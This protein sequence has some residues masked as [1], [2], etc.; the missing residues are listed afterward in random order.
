MKAIAFLSNGNAKATVDML[1]WEKN[2]GIRL[3]PLLRVLSGESFDPDD[4]KVVMGLSVN[5]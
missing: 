4:S 2:S 1:H 3:I 5:L